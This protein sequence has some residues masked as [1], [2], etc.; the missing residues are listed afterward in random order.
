MLDFEDYALTQP[1]MLV[2]ILTEAA[3]QA[4]LEKLLKNLKVYGYSISVV[5]GAVKRLRQF[6]HSAPDQDPADDA[7]AATEVETYA[8]TD[9]EIRVVVSPELADVILYA[10]KDQQ[11][12]FSLLVYRQKI[13]AVVE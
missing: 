8:A 12:Q 10:L 3:L 5:P 13:E 4:S 6:G 2:T 1:A 9:L 7:P 11:R